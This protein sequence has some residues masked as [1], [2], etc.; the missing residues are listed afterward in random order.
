MKKFY[1]TTAIDY[2]NA[3]PHIGHAYEKI[4]A[5]VI[6]RWH[7]LNE[8]NVFFLTG[9]DDNASKNVEAAKKARIPVKQ[10]VDGPA[11]Y[12]P[13]KQLELINDNK[14]DNQKERIY[15]YQK[16]KAEIEDRM[17]TIQHELQPLEH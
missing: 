1:I 11:I 14:W 6:A 17:K 9:T 13:D 2:V 5:D 4:I 10:F 15:T 3:A 16:Q 12:N 7:R 8:E